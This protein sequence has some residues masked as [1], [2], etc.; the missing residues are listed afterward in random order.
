MSGAL[1]GLAL[2]VP[3]GMLAAC[4]SPR[5][6]E[7]MPAWLAVAPAPALLAALLAPGGAVALPPALLRIRLALDVPSAVLLGVAAL[8]WMV[9]GLYATA[10]LRGKPGSERFVAWWLLTLAG[11]VGVFMAAD[12]VSFYL[13]F[14][15]VSLAAYGLVIDDGTA[16]ARRAGLVYVG[17]AVLGEAFLLMAFVLLAQA[18][19]GGSLLIRDGVAA[20]AASPSRDA[21]LALLILGFGAK[22]GMT[23]FH[24]WMPLAYRSAP[25]PA[26]AVLS[27]AAVKAGV[28][29]LI[30]FL[31]PELAMP[32]WGGA[33]AALGLF[34]AYFGVVTGVTQAN[35]KVVLAYSSVSQM[36][37]LAAVFGM[38]L[39]AGDGGVALAAAFYATHH[40]LVKG[41][42]FLSVGVVRETGRRRV[43]LVLAPTAILA[44]SLA[45]LPLTGGVLAKLAVKGPLGSGV[46][47]GLATLSAAGSALLMCHFLRR[48]SDA[49]AT[50]RAAVASRALVLPW[51]GAVTASLAVPWGLYAAL[52]L[53]SV[54]YATS[55]AALFNAGWPVVLGGVLAFG[56]WRWETRLP[57]IPPGDI[58]VYAAGAGRV[59]VAV[60][61]AMELV[62]GALRQWAVAGVSLLT[63]AAILALALW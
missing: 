22:I 28:I 11:S 56:L 14:S 13:L 45:G 12:L 10:W 38:G 20:L 17:L 42:L 39:A 32:G 27:G 44:L 47:S 5:A 16:R 24:V 15:M 23:P 54:A 2:A 8:L 6:R 41:T 19:P 31:P 18:T 59:A 1:L 58:V 26:A 29:G 61:A 9:G 50:D 35:P 55:P 34:S 43:W 62:D 63:L 21:I 30:R 7:R 37:L 3:L 48:L 60:G 53:G 57:R 51:L 52:G 46:V 36:G 49:V 40:I 4:L 33:L 25:I